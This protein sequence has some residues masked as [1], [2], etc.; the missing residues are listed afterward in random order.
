MTGAV[1]LSVLATTALAGAHTE[2]ARTNSTEGDF[3]DV[4]FEIESAVVDRALVLDFHGHS[5]DMLERTADVNEATTPFTD[6]RY[7]DFCSPALTHAAIAA[8]PENLT[9]CPYVV[10][11]CQLKDSPDTV[12]VGYREPGGAG[13]EASEAAPSDIEARPREIVDEVTR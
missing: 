1:A 7:F 10:Y 12:T 2:A 11:A 8:S 3:E 13:D 6:A 5:G 4:V 9:I